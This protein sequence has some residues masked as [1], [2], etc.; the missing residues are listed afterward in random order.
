MNE[1]IG[2]SDLRRNLSAYLRR[3]AGGE[4]I[5]VTDRKRPIAE[6]VPPTRHS[7]VLD[8]LIAEGK[9]IP[10][11]RR[12]TDFEPLK[13]PG[14]PNALTDALLVARADERW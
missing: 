5:I 3:V 8:R 11:R 14:P 10:P 12:R 2:I 4:T 13:T 9:A 6:L 1:E 7:A